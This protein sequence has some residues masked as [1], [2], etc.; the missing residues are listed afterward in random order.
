MQMKAGNLPSHDNEEIQAVP[1]V[2]KVAFLAKDTQGHHFQHHLHSKEDENEVIKYL[3]DTEEK[4]R[5]ILIFTM[6]FTIQEGKTHTH[7]YPRICFP[8]K[9]WYAFIYLTSNR[10]IGNK[11]EFC[12]L[13]GLI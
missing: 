3:K 8:D 5:S 4:L 13:P 11:T 1:G 6:L 2:S 12:K 7:R 9:C 10:V